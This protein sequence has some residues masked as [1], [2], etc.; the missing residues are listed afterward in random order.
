MS[1]LFWFMKFECHR[2]LCHGVSNLHTLSVMNALHFQ[3][4]PL[5]LHAPGRYGSSVAPPTTTTTTWCFFGLCGIAACTPTALLVVLISL[6][7]ILQQRLG[8]PQGRPIDWQASPGSPSSFLVKRILRLDIPVDR[9]PNVSWLYGLLI[10]FIVSIYFF[11]DL[12]WIYLGN[13][14]LHYLL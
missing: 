7:F 12:V 1:L 8:V 6:K 2:K 13:D 9:Y 10:L 4:F 3:A 11:M 5:Q 14:R